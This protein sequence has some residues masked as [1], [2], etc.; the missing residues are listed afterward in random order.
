MGD[1]I[2]D[3]RNRYKRADIH[4]RFIYV[5]TGVFFMTAFV[6]ILLLLFNRSSE[7]IFRWLDLPSS[8]SQFCHQ[9]WSLITYM[10]M[11]ADLIHLLFNMLWLYFFG[12]LFLIFFSARHLRGLYFLGG[13]CG[14]LLYILAYN[15]FPYFTDFVNSSYLLGASASVLAISIAVAVKAPEYKINFLF[16]GAVRLK[17]VASVMIVTDL[18]M[19]TSGNAGGH[20]SHLGGALG[21]WLF[22]SSLTKGHD[23]T[24][25][26]NKAIDF[27][28]GNRTLFYRRRKSKMKTYYGKHRQDY[29]YNI[30]KKE[31]SDEIDRILDKLK[32]SGYDHLTTEEKKRLFDAGKK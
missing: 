2:S 31:Q 3:I 26:I 18:L 20:I 12:R 27:C 15:V 19:I 28:I 7:S 24:S 32:Q 8:V 10:F 5:N 29:E 6:G 11:H 17:Y 1:I 9:P 4:L 23:V 13:I 16:V 25:W 30:R 14:G 22:A 21:G